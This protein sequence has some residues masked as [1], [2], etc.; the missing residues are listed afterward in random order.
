MKKLTLNVFLFISFFVNF[1]FI[2]SFIFSQSDFEIKEQIRIILKSSDLNNDG[3]LNFDELK[4]FYSKYNPIIEDNARTILLANEDSEEEI[5]VEKAVEYIFKYEQSKK[6]KKKVTL[7][8]WKGLKIGRELGDQQSIEGTLIQV[9]AILSVSIS[10]DKSQDKSK[11]S[12][13]LFGDIQLFE[14]IKNFGEF[15]RH[16][17]SFSGG[18]EA[19]INGTDPTP[20]TSLKFALK[21]NQLFNFKSFILSG[22]Q[23]QLN[24]FWNSDREFKRSV[25]GT[26]FSIVPFSKKLRTG[27]WIPANLNSIFRISWIPKI[28]FEFGKILDTGNNEDLQK[29]ITNAHERYTCIGFGTQ[30]YFDQNIVKELKLKAEYSYRWDVSSSHWKNY[31]ISFIASYPLVKV[32]SKYQNA[33]ISFA[34]NY[35]KGEKPPDFIYKNELLFGFGITL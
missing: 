34:V 4:I 20:V 35:R 12:F 22:L 7:L 25:P 28:T 17:F 15:K 1:I 2:N 6:I 9:P 26:L 29:R 11:K 31:F 8:G 5:T 16:T 21:A 32:E 24:L 14:S 27:Y 33:S 10:K 23:I 30:F 3:K 19:D 18:I 13:N